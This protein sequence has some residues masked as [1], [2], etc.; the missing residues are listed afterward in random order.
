MRN[1]KFKI[2]FQTLLEEIKWGLTIREAV[3]LAQ[4]EQIKLGNNFTIKNVYKWNNNLEE[5]EEQE[6]NPVIY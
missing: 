1:Y 5:W 2:I 6:I 3:I 4:G